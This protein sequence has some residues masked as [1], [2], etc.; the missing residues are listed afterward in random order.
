[1][2]EENNSRRNESSVIRSYVGFI[3]IMFS[4]ELFGNWLP[5][6]IPNFTL[7]LAAFWGRQIFGKNCVKGMEKTRESETSAIDYT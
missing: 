1:M 5:T 6:E 3:L 2:V 4:R 7:Q